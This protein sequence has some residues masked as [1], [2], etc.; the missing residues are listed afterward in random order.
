MRVNFTD[1]AETYEYPSYE[2]LLQ[3]MG[4]DDLE[5]HE[6]KLEV[7][8]GLNDEDNPDKSSDIL[9]NKSAITEES[10]QVVSNT[11]FTQF[12]PGRRVNLAQDNYREENQ[13]NNYQNEDAL[14]LEAYNCENIESSCDYTK[15]LE[16]TN[17][18]DSIVL[19]E[20]LLSSEMDS[21][22]K[23]NKNTFSKLGMV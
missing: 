14:Q 12:L 8:I 11:C 10:H 21:N 13:T 18:H 4:I 20:N 9:R 3:E 6:K 19:Y 15:N 17:D 22:K 16:H 1:V 7:L 2:F 5:D 23:E